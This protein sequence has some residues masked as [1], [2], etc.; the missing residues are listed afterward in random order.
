MPQSELNVSWNLEVSIIKH[1]RKST[2]RSP[3]V[4]TQGAGRGLLMLRENVA[5]P[6]HSIFSSFFS[7]SSFSCTPGLKQSL[8]AAAVAS[9][10]AGRSLN[11]QAGN[12]PL[13]LEELWSQESAANPMAFLLP[14]LFC[15]LALM[16]A[17]SW[18]VNSRVGLLKPQLS[19]GSLEKESPRQLR[20]CKRM[21]SLGNW[22]LKVTYG[23]SWLPSCT[24][25]SVILTAYRNT[26]DWNMG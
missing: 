3:L 1:D 8:A 4:L 7:F 6:Q 5:I 14:L 24:Y 12:F 16:W 2:R 18:E 17:Q 25:L 23:I 26:E 15:C 21:R 9:V 19:A 11:L 13:R 10:G 20:D 22:L